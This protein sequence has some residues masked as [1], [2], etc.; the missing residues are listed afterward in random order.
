MNIF[1]S[2]VPQDG[3]RATEMAHRKIELQA[4][5]DLTYLIANLSR[6]ARE[7]LDKHLPPDAVPEGEDAM[8]TRVEELVDDVRE[9][10]RNTFTAAKDS[11]SINGMDAKEM[12]AEVAK[13]QEGEEIEPFDTRLAQRLQ[14]LSSQI[15]H[16]TLQLANLRR[17]APAETARR[18]Q[19][20]YAKDTQEYDTRM[21]EVEEREL[22]AARE[23]KV[24]PGHIERADEMQST[25]QRG[26][27]ELLALKS[28]LG[29]TVARL[30]KAQKAVDVVGEK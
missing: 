14:T 16:Q 11:M 7:K 3:T 5:A 21:R 27:D 8:R 30:E 26:S 9:Y 23:T 17:T 28:G 4:P 25:W 13:A 15:E 1:E 2:N 24:D 10:I 18:F 12:E 29:S 20:R 19:E 22:Q 6:A